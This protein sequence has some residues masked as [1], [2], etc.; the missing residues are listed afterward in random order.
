MGAHFV[1]GHVDGQGQVVAIERAGRDWMLTVA[2][3]AE[4]LAEMVPKGSITIDGTS[5]TIAALTETTFTVCII[6]H[7][8]T[9]TSLAAL[10]V[11]AAVNLE[12]DMIGKYVRR[13]LGLVEGGGASTLTM[14][15][16]RDA[17]F[18]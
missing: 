7:T 11:A 6:P 12:T 5:L 13:S 8:W 4:R 9:H 17:G 16:L 3:A 1:T 14:D 15:R 2:C 18:M 10:Q